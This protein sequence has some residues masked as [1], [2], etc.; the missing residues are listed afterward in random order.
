MDDIGVRSG[1]FGFYEWF[2]ECPHALAEPEAFG[3][4]LPGGAAAC[5]SAPW[6]ADAGGGMGREGVAVLQASR[7]VV[8]VVVGVVL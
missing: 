7:L 8:G 4:E 1:D 5:G 2:C 6:A 3:L